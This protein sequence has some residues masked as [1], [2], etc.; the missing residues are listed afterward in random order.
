MIRIA[1]LIFLVVEL[2]T[3]FT[4][5]HGANRLYFLVTIDTETSIR[6]GPD[7]WYPTSIEKEILGQRSE[8]TYG[9]PLMMDILDKHNM[10]ATFF[11]DTSLGSY[12]PE[13][14]VG[15]VVADIKR[16]GHDVQLHIHPE[17]LC[18]QPCNKTDR[19]C[20]ETCVKETYFFRGNSYDN[21]L[22]LIR[23]G[24]ERIA[25][26]SGQYPVAFRAGKV[27]ADEV[28]LRVLRDLHIPIDS[29]LHLPSDPLH[30]MLPINKVSEH[31]GVIELPEFTYRENIV[32]AG[33]Y[34]HLDLESSTLEEQKR[35][36]TAAIENDVRTIVLLLHSHSFCREAVGCPLTENVERFDSL[37]SYVRTMENVT[38][39]TMNDF[40]TRYRA[41][42]TAFVGSGY[43]PEIG[44][45]LL[46]KRSFLRFD[47]QWQYRVFA[48]ANVT[49]VVLFGGAAVVA[50]VRLVRRRRKPS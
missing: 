4:L 20:F 7:G 49:A 3:S 47:R 21:Q 25:T 40:L 10:K 48:V 12:Y 11:V 18:F 34:A 16:R 32:L 35:L 6:R 46:L 36:I 1:L 30:E 42:K 22:K 9:I 24:A 39:I 5:A 19:S 31:E 29:D 2:I 50:I 43:I 14:Q 33:R 37:L 8:G 15:R 26:W 45:V 13:D 28:T 44:Y 41:D 23:E 38:P 27:D 17:F